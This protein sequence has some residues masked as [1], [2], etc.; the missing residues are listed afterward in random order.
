MGDRY[1]LPDIHDQD[2]E[3]VVERLT[4]EDVR[5][6]QSCRDEFVELPCAACHSTDLTFEFEAHGF[7][8]KRCAS[9]G[10]LM[11]SPAPDA[12]R[13][14]WYIQ[15]SEALRFW[16]EHMPQRVRGSRS[17]MYEERAAYVA[18][19]IERAGIEVQHV[20]EI[21]A[22]NGE[23]AEALLRSPAVAIKRMVL[24]E[25]QPLELSLPQVEVVSIPIEQWRSD[26]QFEVAVS[27]EVLEHVLDPD[28]MLGAVVRRL[29][30]GGLLVL[31]TPNERSLETGLLQ[32]RSSNLLYDHVR[33]YNPTSIRRLLER[34]GFE[35]VAVSTPGQLDVEILHRHYVAGHMNLTN[36]PALQFLLE[37]G[38]RHRAEFQQFLCGRNLS[39]HMRCVARLH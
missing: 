22:G 20:L 6:L 27:W 13:Q 39:S 21:G 32:G 38:Y 2:L 29:V 33:L 5:R 25:P 7:E 37:D 23:F 14:L 8:Y 4:L 9:C 26:E 31:S 12:A 30:R 35:I 36:D 34:F 18:S 3:A 10:L 16:R 19:F 28:P 1:S 11:L 24:I 17:K 15:N